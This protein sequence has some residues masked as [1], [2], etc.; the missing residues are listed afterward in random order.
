M[1]LPVSDEPSSISDGPS[2]ESDELLIFIFV[3]KDHK[4]NRFKTN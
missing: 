4:N 2:S 1:N 3:F